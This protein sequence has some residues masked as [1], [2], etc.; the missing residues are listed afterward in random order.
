MQ[1]TRIQI[2]EDDTSYALEL[3][4]MLTK[5]G[6]EVLPLIDEPSEWTL[7]DKNLPDLVLTDIFFNGKPEG[8][9][10]VASVQKRGIPAVVITASDD[11]DVYERTKVMFPGGY[12][13]KPVTPVS[14]NAVIENALKYPD[15]TEK[16]SLALERW[17]KKQII[18]KFLFV[19]HGKGLVKLEVSE[20]S[21]IEA[22]GNYCYIHEKGKRYVA[23]KSL[24][25]FKKGLL[26]Q[27]FLQV[28]RSQ[29]VNFLMIDQLSFSNARIVVAGQT[30]VIGDA[31]R[32]EI[33]SWLNLL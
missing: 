11:P 33:A 19:R 23:N 12:I 20:I 15:L 28:N 26:N 6:Y 4:M 22:D 29:L 24:R 17:S 16:V 25:K 18:K 8:I 27:G 5:L 21:L 14:L 32:D 1:K 7:D 3:E 2:V 13:E 10:V 31:Y 9:K 30:L